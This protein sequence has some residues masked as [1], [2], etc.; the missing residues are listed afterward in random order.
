MKI[1]FSLRTWPQHHLLL[2]CRISVASEGLMKPVGTG[3]LVGSA[4]SPHSKCGYEPSW[5]SIF[6]ASGSVFT[7]TVTFRAL[8]ASNTNHVTKISLWS[9]RNMHNVVWAYWN[10]KS[11]QSKPCPV[12]LTAT[13]PRALM[14]P[15]TWS[16]QIRW[17]GIQCHIHF[18]FSFYT[19]LH[20]FL[21]V[22]LGQ[23]QQE[24]RLDTSVMWCWLQWHYYTATILL[25]SDCPLHLSV[26]SIWVGI[27]SN[28]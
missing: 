26:F 3:A 5:L 13:Q 20:L 10:T 23:S 8:D 15:Q 7:W 14:H 16:S 1:V 28:I 17:D 4:G 22:K 19:A 11:L 25:R 6:S 18:L 12:K 24:D 2:V 27:Y 21:F 9:R